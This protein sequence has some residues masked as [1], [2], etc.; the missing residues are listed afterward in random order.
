MKSTDYN[1]Y[2]DLV[3]KLDDE[4]TEGFNAADPKQVNAAKRVAGGSEASDREVMKQL[5]DYRP[6]RAFLWRLFEKCH[7]FQTSFM[8]ESPLTTAFRE[9]ERNIG[10]RLFEQLGQANPTAYT[11]ML[12]EHREEHY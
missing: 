12:R 7:M 11:Q 5:T 10:L 3:D 4:E 2:A 1:V 9:G 8:A 6:G